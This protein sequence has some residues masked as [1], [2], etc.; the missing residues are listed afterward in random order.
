MED[1]LYYLGRAIQ[2]G[3][4]LALIAFPDFFWGDLYDSKITPRSWVRS[5]G[6]TGLPDVVFKILRNAL[7]VLVVFALTQILIMAG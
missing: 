4:V 7:I 3:I 2:W 1:F 5:W 6:N